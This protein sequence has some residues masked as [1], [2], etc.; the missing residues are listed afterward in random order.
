MSERWVVKKSMDGMTYGVLSESGTIIAG[1]IPDKQ[2]AEQIA[3]MREL[4]AVLQEGIDNVKDLLSVYDRIWVVLGKKPVEYEN[5]SI[6][7]LPGAV[8]AELTRLEKLANYYKE[9]LTDTLKDSK[10]IEEAVIGQKGEID[11]LRKDLRFIKEMASED[12]KD[13]RAYGTNLFQIEA[14]A[15]AALGENTIDLSK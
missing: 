15:R 8:K 10:P 4:A 6:D 12:I 11:R 3:E 14:N 7:Q 1:Q 9:H 2:I 5:L 13:G